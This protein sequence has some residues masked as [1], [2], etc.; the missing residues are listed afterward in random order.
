MAGIT[1]HRKRRLSIADDVPILMSAMEEE[2]RVDLKLAVRRSR[3]SGVGRM[4]EVPQNSS[5]A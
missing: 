3:D 2:Q 5:E 4:R 1:D